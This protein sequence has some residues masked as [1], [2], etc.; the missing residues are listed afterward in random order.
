MSKKTKLIV[1]GPWVGEFS[2]EMSWWVHEIRKLR[3][4]VYKDYKAIHVGYLGRRAL[5]KD[6]IDQYIAYPNK[7]SDS[8]TGQPSAQAIYQKGKHIIPKKVVGFFNETIKQYSK[9]Y[10]LVDTHLPSNQLATRVRQDHPFGEFVNLKPDPKIVKQVKLK[11]KQFKHKRDVIALN[12]RSRFRDGKTDREDWNPN[13]WEQF[14]AKIIRE[15]K[16]NI[17]VT[18]VPRKG[19]QP[20]SLDFK[21]SDVLKPYKHYL[22]SFI[23]EGVDSVEHQA[24]LLVS[25]KCSI[26]GATGAVTLAFLTN[27]PVFTQQTKQNG[28]RLHYAWQKKLTG[29]HKRVK[30]FDK[31]SMGDIYNSPVDE[32]YR[33][34]IKFYRKL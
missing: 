12:A 28:N 1:F 15:L 8:I 24:A 31:L 16:V 13:H 33:E 14:I 9:S 2:Y 32:L 5:Y 22:K 6:F 19:N 29:G 21:N 7:V 18:G 25:T 30:V 27:T 4:T 34:F 23:F 26:W 17:A 11:L 20:G 10:S 3:H